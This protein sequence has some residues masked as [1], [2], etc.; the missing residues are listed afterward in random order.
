MSLV[1]CEQGATSGEDL[2]SSDEGSNFASLSDEMEQGSI[3]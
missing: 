1:G 2:Y 3:G